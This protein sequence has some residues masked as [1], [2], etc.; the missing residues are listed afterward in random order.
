MAAESTEQGDLQR[1]STYTPVG[2]TPDAA[3]GALLSIRVTLSATPGNVTAITLP[4]VAQGFRLYPA[5][6]DIRFAIGEDPAA[7]ATSAS[8]PI[9]A[10]AFAV[11]A[12]A[13]ADTWET[14]L[15]AAGASRTLRLRSA[16]ASVVVEIGVF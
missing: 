4:D 16:T 9:A 7:E 15:V 6:N 5:S 12:V 3:L 2:L 10:A 14:R 13:K 11:G 1:A 8:T